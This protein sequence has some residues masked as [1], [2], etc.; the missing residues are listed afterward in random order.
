MCFSGQTKGMQCRYN[1]PKPLRSESSF[2]LKNDKIVN[3]DF[4]RNDVYTWRANVDFSPILT[5][6]VVYRYIAKYA[7]K[8]EKKSNTYYHVLS[9]IV[10]KACE[11][12]K[13]AKKATRK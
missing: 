6:E 7:S 10:N 9:E 12:S 4:K 2:E 5:K 8:S 3:I 13:Y 1:F 11:Q